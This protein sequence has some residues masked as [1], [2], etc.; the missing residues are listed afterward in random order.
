M[1]LNSAKRH[2][3]FSSTGHCIWCLSWY[4]I[5][6][7]WLRTTQGGAYP[8]CC[9]SMQVRLTLVVLVGVHGVQD[10]EGLSRSLLGEEAMLCRGH[11]VKHS[12]KDL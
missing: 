2:L 11:R 10:R 12:G 8:F 3:G 6:E 9:S 4:G 1:E 5:L 7:S